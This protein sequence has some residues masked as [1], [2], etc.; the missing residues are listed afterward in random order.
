MTDLL[1]IHKEL[2]VH[3]HSQGEGIDRIGT[4]QLLISS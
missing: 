4:D 3:V 1:D 2:D